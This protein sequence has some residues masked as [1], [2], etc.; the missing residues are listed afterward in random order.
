MAD[1]ALET[2]LPVTRPS[3]RL[4]VSSRNRP[5]KTRW[6]NLAVTGADSKANV[7]ML[8]LDHAASGTNLTEASHIFL[9]G[10]S[11]GTCGSDINVFALDP[12]SGTREEAL[13]TERQ[14]I[15]RAHRL[16]QNSQVTVVRMI[17]SKYF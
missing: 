8:S 17:I 10:T 12:V 14:A 5:N 3:R 13:A 1:H 15:G 11:S 6:S 9:I 7:I 4:K 2:S 16:G